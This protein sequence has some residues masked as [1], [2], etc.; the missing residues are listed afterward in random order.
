MEG[1]ASGALHYKIDWPR[2]TG[3]VFL[4][5]TYLLSLSAIVKWQARESARVSGRVLIPDLSQS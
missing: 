1:W 3:V 5:P 4:M 2:Q